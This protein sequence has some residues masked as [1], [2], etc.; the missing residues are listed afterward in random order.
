MI[1]LK[2]IARKYNLSSSPARVMMVLIS[3][4]VCAS[5]IIK[6]VFTRLRPRIYDNGSIIN[7]LSS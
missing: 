5:S 3:E 2:D 6:N 4:E 1:N 7:I